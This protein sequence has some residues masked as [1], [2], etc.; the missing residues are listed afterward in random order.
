MLVRYTSQCRSTATVENTRPGSVSTVVAAPVARSM[1]SREL[2]VGMLESQVSTPL[3]S[4]VQASA[5]SDSRS[6]GSV[7]VPATP[8]PSDRAQT[9]VV[10]AVGSYPGQAMYFPSWDQAMFLEALAF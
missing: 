9:M 8:L 3:S 7:T 1:Y 10:P 5:L 6:P 2:R 4:G